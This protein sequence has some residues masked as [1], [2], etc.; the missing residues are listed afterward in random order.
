MIQIGD[1]EGGD[2]RFVRTNRLG[3]HFGRKRDWARVQNW[4]V[5]KIAGQHWWQ[6]VAINAHKCEKRNT[7][8]YQGGDK[9]N[10]ID[11]QNHCTPVGS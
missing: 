6:L 9:H 11:N 3:S 4:F 5:C 7:M 1:K 10:L 2:K 8:Q